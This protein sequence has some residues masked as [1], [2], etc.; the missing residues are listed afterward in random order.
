MGHQSAGGYAGARSAWRRLAEQPARLADLPLQAEPD[1]KKRSFAL[2]KV[3]DLQ[4]AVKGEALKGRQAAEAL[5]A[6]Q[7][8]GAAGERGGGGA[9]GEELGEVAPGFAVWT[10]VLESG[11]IGSG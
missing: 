2:R 1:E 6:V 7:A 11:S 5:A 9:E 3:A 8:L 10:R 4:E